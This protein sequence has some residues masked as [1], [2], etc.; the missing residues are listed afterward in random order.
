M[1]LFAVLS[2]VGLAWSPLL[3]FAPLLA[4]MVLFAGAQ[5]AVHACRA[6]LPRQPSSP[7]RRLGMRALIAFLYLMQPLARCA[8]RTHS[9]LTPWRLRGVHGFAWPVS[10]RVESWSK[11]WEDPFR[12]L[13]DLEQAL[14]EGGA[15]VIRGHEFARWDLELRGGLIGRIRIRQFTA[16]LPHRAQLIRLEGHPRCAGIAVLL[17]L[18][19]TAIIVGATRQQE[20]ALAAAAW[21]AAAGLA[22]VTLREVSAAMATFKRT[23]NRVLK[24]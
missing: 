11:E 8:G 5:A 1:A 2:L 14:R 19:L 18:L 3:L 16:D 9:G 12:R 15:V 23:A 7:A 21:L 10:A 17:F 6:S 4:A 24:P 20:Y 22:G 13:A